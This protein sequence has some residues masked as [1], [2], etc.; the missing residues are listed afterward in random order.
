MTGPA[1]CTVDEHK[2]DFVEISVAQGFKLAFQF[3][4]HRR[5]ADA[6]AGMPLNKVGKAPFGPVYSV[7]IEREPTSWFTPE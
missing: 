3:S 2:P 6:V 1:I 4:K 7:L 5:V